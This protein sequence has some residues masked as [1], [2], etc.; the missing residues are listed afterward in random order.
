MLLLRGHWGAVIVKEEL[1]MAERAPIKV[2]VS[3]VDGAVVVAPEGEI[4]YLEAPTFKVFLRQGFERKPKRLIADLAGVPYM[5]TPGVATL[6][7]ALQQSKKQAI[8]LVLCGM[9]E[10]V[11]SIFEIARLHTVFKI[12]ATRDDAIRL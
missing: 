12:V 9:N 3:S 1:N 7:E 2:T 10:R 6:V 4:G 8:S 5:S 11:M